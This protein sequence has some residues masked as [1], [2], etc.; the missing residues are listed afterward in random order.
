MLPS[1]VLIGMY[2]MKGDGKTQS[3]KMLLAR[4]LILECSLVYC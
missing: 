4:L 2:L 3:Y 1:S